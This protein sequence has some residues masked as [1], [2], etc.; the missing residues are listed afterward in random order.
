MQTMSAMP[1]TPAAAQF[2]VVA[3]KVVTITAAAST[4][5]SMKRSPWLKLISSMM[6]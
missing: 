1:R 6:P 2:V 5:A 3:P 4:V